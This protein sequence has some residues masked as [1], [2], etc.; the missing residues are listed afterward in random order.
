MAKKSIRKLIKKL[1][2][3][4]KPRNPVVRV[5]KLRNQKAG[6]HTISNRKAHDNKYK[7][8]SKVIH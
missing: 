1:L 7:C 4:V 5:M 6:A 3:E 2:K 8:R